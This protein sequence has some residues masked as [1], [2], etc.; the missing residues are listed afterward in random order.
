MILSAYIITRPFTFRAALPAVWV[1]ALPL[2]R[3]PSLSASRIATKE[4]VGMSNPSRSRFTP[5]STSKSPFLKSSMISTRSNVSTSEWI[6]LHRTPTLVKYCSSSSAILLVR[7]V[8]R[9]LSSC[10]ALTLISSRRSSIWFSVGR[11]SIGG[12]SSPVGRTTCSTTRPSDFSS[13]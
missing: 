1:N 9:T 3:K 4:T 10:S 12:S 5:T 6:Y 11:T 2:R 7:V 8:T 13:S